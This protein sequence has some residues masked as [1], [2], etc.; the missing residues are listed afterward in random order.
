MRYRPLG[1]TGFH[2]SALS[3]GASALGGVYGEAPEADS[4]RAVHAALDAGINYLDVSPYYGL[5]RA[6]T[7]LGKA[8]R[9]V[10]RDRYVISTKAGR[11]GHDAFDMSPQ[12]LQQS[13]EASLVR[14]GLD[15]V[16]I[17]LLHDV[18]FVPWR[19]VVEESLPTLRDFQRQGTIRWYGLS[20]FPLTVFNR[21][22]AEQIPVDLI[23][24]YGHYALHD[25]TLLDLLP[26]LQARQIGVI[27]ASPFG[28]GLLTDQGPPAWHPAP[29]V[30]Q[31][32]CQQAAAYCRTQGHSLAELAIQFA[33]SQPTLATTLFSACNPTEVEQTVRW[34][35]ELP[36]EGLLQDVL[37]QLQPIQGQS[38]PSGLPE[39][40]SLQ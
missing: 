29:T 13:L 2:V 17:L 10:P 23:L 18:E 24:S 5:T 1:Q 28:M 16:D 35:E 40:A 36:E 25:R 22:V 31:Q 11:D 27:N 30:I 33:V 20:G 8:L 4:I 3:F 34:A 6:E 19:Q 12:H 32:I 9:G 21:I 15:S 37:S 38:W 7:V 39:Y 26:A 14:L